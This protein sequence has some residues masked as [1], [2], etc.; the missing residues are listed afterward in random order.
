MQFLSLLQ[1]AAPV[2]LAALGE[3]I[4]QRSGVIDIALEGVM[5]GGAF[6]GLMATIAT[7]SPI[8]GAG[9]GILAGLCVA[10]LFGWF[11]I[12]LTTDQVVVG[13]A[14]NLLMLGITGTLFRARFGQSGQLLSVAKIPAWHGVDPVLV[15]LVLSVPAV[16]YLLGRTGWGLALRSAGEYPKAT[17]AAGYSVHRLRLGAVLIGGA[18]GGLA[19]AYLSLGIAGSFAENMT[20]G[21]GFVAIALVT[22]GRW[23][24]GWVFAA[25]LLIGFL[26]SLQFR[27]QSLGLHIPYQLLVAL[28]YV[29]ALLVLVAAGKGT[30]APGALGQPYR[31]E[32]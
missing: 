15:F 7:G 25:A 4:C 20:A 11:T 1:Y 8:L 13:T 18:F 28:P 21:R 16:W 24:P 32:K 12:Y 9:V 23:R 29:V 19:G 22:F 31:R 5:L 2:A 27:F 3:T 10:A 17:E 30:I 26:E 6:F 14:V